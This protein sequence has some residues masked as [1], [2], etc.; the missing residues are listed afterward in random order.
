MTDFFNYAIDNWYFVGMNLYFIGSFY[1]ELSELIFIY[2]QKIKNNFIF[3]LT[4]IGMTVLYVAISYIWLPFI[5][6][7]FVLTSLGITGVNNEEK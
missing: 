3:L 6:L 5:F 4:I 2:N 7:V 1:F